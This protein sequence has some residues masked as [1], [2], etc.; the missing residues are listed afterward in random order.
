MYGL[1]Q[2]DGC[3][4]GKE[5]AGVVSC[6]TDEEGLESLF[7]V[8]PTPKCPELCLNRGSDELA[9]PFVENTQCARL[10][11]EVCGM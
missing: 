5:D 7:P 4:W 8:N 3:R 6:S 11:S 1:R 2:R 10:E 9:T